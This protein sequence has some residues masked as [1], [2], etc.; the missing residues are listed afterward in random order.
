MLRYVHQPW[1]DEES[2]KADQE[3]A[4]VSCQEES[5]KWYASTFEVEPNRGKL[6]EVKRGSES[7]CVVAA[8]PSLLLFAPD[9]LEGIITSRGYEITSSNHKS[10]CL[11]SS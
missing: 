10:T 3:L 11:L 2:S 5:V 6:K 1:V 9:V 8:L 4:D 7:T